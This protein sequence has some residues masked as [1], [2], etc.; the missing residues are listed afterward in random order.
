MKYTVTLKTMLGD[1]HGTLEMEHL[2]RNAK[3]MLHIL[4]N[5]TELHGSIS[6]NGKCCLEGVLKTLM[7]TKP[8]V[9]EGCM[10]DHRLSL[11]LRGQGESWAMTGVSV[12]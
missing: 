7:T 4:G 6:E 3:G 10:N 9:A 11:L 8:F 12:R 2:G 5:R 1:R